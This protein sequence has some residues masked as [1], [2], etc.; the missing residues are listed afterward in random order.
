MVKNDVC[1]YIIHSPPEMQERDK[2]KVK[3]SAIEN[4][5]VYIAKSTS[6]KWINHLDSLVN[7]GDEFDTRMGW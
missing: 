1:S 6:Y 3:I 4:A 2:L 7:N 5:D